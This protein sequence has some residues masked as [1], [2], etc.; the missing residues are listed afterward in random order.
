MILLHSILKHVASQ[1]TLMNGVDPSQTPDKDLQEKEKEAIRKLSAL[2]KSYVDGQI[3]LQ[4]RYVYVVVCSYQG[5]F[6]LQRSRY[7]RT[8]HREPS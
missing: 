2:I 8:L 6:S 4:V 3:K 7:S 1:S 5:K